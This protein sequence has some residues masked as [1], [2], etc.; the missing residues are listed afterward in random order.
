MLSQF[1]GPSMLLVPSYR[2]SFSPHLHIHT[3]GSKIA[4]RAIARLGEPALFHYEVAIRG[5]VA[6]TLTRRNAT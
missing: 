4:R 2:Y 1:E 3:A 5:F 6:R